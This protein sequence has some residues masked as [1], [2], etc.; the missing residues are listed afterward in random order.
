MAAAVDPIIP[1]GMMAGRFFSRLAPALAVAMALAL[2]PFTPT[3]QATGTTTG[4]AGPLGVASSHGGNHDPVGHFDA[5]TAGPSGVSVRGWA[6]D[7]DVTR[8]VYVWVTVDGVGRHLHARTARPDV[9]RAY[10]GYGDSHGFA[11]DLA[12]DPGRR[13]VC[14]TVANVGDGA[15]RSLGCREVTVPG[16]SPFGNVERLAGVVGGIELKGWALDPDTTRPIYLWVTVDGVGQHL[17][18]NRRRAD[19]DRAFGLGA[20][21]GFGATVPATPGSHWVCVTAANVAAGS[22][23]QLTC[24]LVTTL[25]GSQATVSDFEADVLRLTNEARAAN[26]LPPYAPSTCA[27]AQARARAG[28][29]LGSAELS[30]A[31]L[32][33]VLAA[34]APMTAAGENLARGFLTAERM[35]QAWLDSPAH[36][37]NLLHPGLTQ[38]GVGC[39][40]TGGAMLCSQVFLG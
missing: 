25:I 24:G 14:V 29:L 36:R 19:V 39:V 7:P 22:H 8:P 32:D 28:A 30:H 1:G 37:D 6:L 35:V 26:G 40:P 4:L 20:D 38:I 31:P 15:H 10:P 16:G 12:A 27:L 33:G 21:H 2:V 3:A 11:G 34:C 18:A 5:L 13:R 9:G 17:N 23:Q